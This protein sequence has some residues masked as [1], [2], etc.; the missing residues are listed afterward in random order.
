MNKLHFC[1]SAFLITSSITHAIAVSENH[2][3]YTTKQA[4]YTTSLIAGSLGSCALSLFTLFKAGENPNNPALIPLMSLSLIS[5]YSFF[6]QIWEEHN[7]IQKLS[8]QQQKKEHQ[9]FVSYVMNMP[10]Q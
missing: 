8:E 2:D 7:R 4:R 6:T 1:L 5:S 9:A 10:E 3:P